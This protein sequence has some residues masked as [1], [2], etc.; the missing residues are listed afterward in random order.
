M[1][2]TIRHIELR[3]ADFLVRTSALSF[4][5]RRRLVRLARADDRLPSRHSLRHRR[6]RLSAR[7]RDRSAG[8]GTAGVGAAI[9]LL[10]GYLLLAGSPG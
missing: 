3:R 2:A 1:T 8:L 4:P 5:A 9:A 10:I 6:R 7:W